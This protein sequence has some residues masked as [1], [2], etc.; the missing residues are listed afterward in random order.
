VGKSR[1]V[2][3]LAIFE[4]YA[5]VMTG[6]WKY[7]EFGTFP[8]GLQ[9]VQEPTDRILQRRSVVVLATVDHQNRRLHLLQDRDWIMVEGKRI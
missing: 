4:D 9:G 2:L 5:K 7:L 3:F 8:A 6:R 1:E